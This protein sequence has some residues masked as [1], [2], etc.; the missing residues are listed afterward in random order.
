MNGTHKLPVYTDDINVLGDNRN[1]LK[2]YIEGLS[3]IGSDVT[4]LITV[5]MKILKIG[6]SN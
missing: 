2:R 1:I 3:V 4:V 6:I 5:T